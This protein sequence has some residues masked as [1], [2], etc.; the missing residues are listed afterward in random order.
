MKTT[1]K[2]RVLAISQFVKESFVP[3][4]VRKKD[5]IA[6]LNWA[7]R[8]TEDE[9]NMEISLKWLKDLNESHTSVDSEVPNE[10]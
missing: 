5:V 1:P 2:Q 10:T 3:D 8:V 7:A 6:L 9:K 4:M